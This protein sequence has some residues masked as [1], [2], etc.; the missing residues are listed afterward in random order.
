MAISKDSSKI[1]SHRVRKLSGD[2]LDKV[3]GGQTGGYKSGR[4]MDNHG[5][6]FH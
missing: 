4:G 1:F 5:M 3:V 2:E 6:D